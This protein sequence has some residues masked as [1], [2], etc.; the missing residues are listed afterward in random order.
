MWKTGNKEEKY[1]VYE[2]MICTREKT[3]SRR[4]EGGWVCVATSLDSVDKEGMWR[5]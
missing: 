1:I 5:G 3:K 2:I 4:R